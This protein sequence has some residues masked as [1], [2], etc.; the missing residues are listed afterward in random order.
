MKLIL[1][2]EPLTPDVII[3][4]IFKEDECQFPLKE[5]MKDECVTTLFRSRHENEPDVL[6][7]GLGSK[8]NTTSDSIRNAG[9]NCGRELFNNGYKVALISKNTLNANENTSN[10]I[11]NFVEGVS[12]GNYKFTDYFIKT[13]PE[14]IDTTIAVDNGWDN[15]SDESIKELI[16]TVSARSKGVYITRNLVNTPSED[17]NPEV[18]A[19]K[20]IDMFKDTPIDVKVYYLDDLKN[21]NFVGTLMVGKGSNNPPV[22]VELSYTANN[23]SPLVALVGKGV[24]YDMGGM[25]VKTA[26]NGTGMKSDMGGSAAVVG[27]FNIIAELK[28]NLNVV[29]LLPLAENLPDAGAMLP[30]SVIKYPNGVSVEVANTDAEGR[31]ILADAL[32]YASELK[33][34]YIIDIATL[35]GSIA[36]A[37]GGRIAGVFGKDE[38]IKRL[39]DIGKNCGDNIWP[40]PLIKEY[41]EKIKSSYAD[42]CNISNDAGGGSIT[43]AL[44]LN[45]FVS[46]DSE[47]AHIDMAGIALTPTDYSYNPKGATGFG[48]RLLY[49]LVCDI[50]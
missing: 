3:T 36:N 1:K 34:K 24:T 26:S 13:K 47:W 38:L 4:P 49:D 23:T 45:N 30:S 14:N 21:K 19:K 50:K 28:P 31:L 40:M 17:L 7:V 10:N 32:I 27:T 5:S 44:F 18:Y 46:K 15:I 48:A 33:A 20:I 42:I 2:S 16:E 6:I 39:H 22:F 41:E 8:N 12:L 25:N 11:A 9:G 29:G 37:L 35:T 43:A